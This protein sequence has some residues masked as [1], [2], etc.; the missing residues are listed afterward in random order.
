MNAYSE[1]RSIT[2]VSVEI[3]EAHANSAYPVPDAD[4]LHVSPSAYSATNIL[5]IRRRLP[6]FSD[7]SIVS[8]E[9]RILFLFFVGGV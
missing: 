2:R 6:D 8:S 4:G 3:F 7:R 1:S 9:Y 5:L